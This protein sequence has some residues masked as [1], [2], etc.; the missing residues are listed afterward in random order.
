MVGEA[1]QHCLFP[2][3]MRGRCQPEDYTTTQGATAN[4]ATTRRRAV[5]VSLMVEDQG[6]RWVVSVV[7]TGPKAEGMQ[8]LL[9]PA[10]A[11]VLGQFKDEAL[12]GPCTRRAVQAT[13]LVEDQSAK[14]KAAIATVASGAEPMEHLVGP[15]SVLVGRKL[16]Y[17]TIAGGIAAVLRHPVEISCLVGNQ[18]C[19]GVAPVRAIRH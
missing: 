4:I 9:G 5:Q 7:T 16:E 19:N 6:T 14:R 8:N 17:R 2:S 13:R 12:C 11:L 1:M 3:T 18:T 15:A 10:P